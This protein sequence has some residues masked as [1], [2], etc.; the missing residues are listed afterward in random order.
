MA[1]ASLCVA[2]AAVIVFDLRTRTIPNKLAAAIALAGFGHAVAFGG[3]RAAAASLLG[4]ACGVA[5][6]LW[7]FHRGIMGA[8]DVKLLGALG[9]WAGAVGT[10]YI[11]ILGS[12]LGGLVALVALALLARE[13]R[14]DVARNVVGFA[15]EGTLPVPEPAKLERSRGIPY[16]VALA[17]AG[18]AV[19]T[20][21]IGR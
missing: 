4:A 3:A 17:A 2:L 16:G 6:L 15:R 11:F 14:Q 19:L 8:G 20:L 7:Q 13:A 12:V 10:L 1:L 18:A 9:S 21:G 5:M